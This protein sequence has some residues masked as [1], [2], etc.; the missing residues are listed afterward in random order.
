MWM[1]FL[2]SS[3]FDFLS[4]TTHS[5]P[6]RRWPNGQSWITGNDAKRTL[7]FY[8]FMG[9]TSSWADAYALDAVQSWPYKEI[10]EGRER[11]FTHFS[12]FFHFPITCSL[13]SFVWWGNVEE[14][15][16]KWARAK[17]T[18]LGPVSTFL[19]LSF[20]ETAQ[21]IVT[22]RVSVH[23]QLLAAFFLLISFYLLWRPNNWRFARMHTSD[24]LI[25][26]D[27]HAYAC[28]S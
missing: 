19:F 17:R 9:K 25:L 28:Y 3:H 14:I 1:K 21:E 2:I 26:M 6:L 4:R 15:M 11:N 18:I 5:V 16:K 23:T 22:L 7:P 13:I 12:Y 24:S 10:K 20:H 27:D 8:F